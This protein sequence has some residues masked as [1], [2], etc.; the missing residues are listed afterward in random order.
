[1]KLFSG[2]AGV[3]LAIAAIFFL[4]YSIEHGWLEPPVRV[5]IGI[6]VSIGLLV[7]CELK[8]ARQY[9]VTANALD[10]AA[11]AILFA[12]FFAAH[13]LWNLI[14]GGVAFGLLALVTAVAVL[15]SIRRDS[16]F[17]A[18]LGLLGGFATPALL[19]TGENRPIPLFAYLLLL[20]LGLAWVAYR[21]RWPLLS[22]LTVALTAVYQWGWVFKFL[23][24]SQLSLATGIFLLF[25][26]VTVVALILARR[27][28]SGACKQ[29]RVD[30]RA[31]GA[32]RGRIAVALRRL[33]CCG[34]GLRTAHRH[35]VRLLLLVDAGLLAIALARKEEL[36][37]AV[38]AAGTVAVLSLWLS[39]SY[40]AGRYTTPLFMLP[41]F[42]TL[43]LF[44]P[45]LARRLARPFRREARHAVYVAPLLL[46]AF[47]VFAG[48]P[49][50][51]ASPM[52]LFAVLLGLVALLAWRALALS[53]GALYFPALFFSI[54][55]QAVWTSRN[56]SPERFGDAM[57]IYAALGALSLGVPLAARR[58]KRSLLPSWGSG[59]VLLASLGF[60]MFLATGP[61]FPPA[62]WGFALLTL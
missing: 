2:I 47:A 31:D 12:T 3:A 44:A 38:G 21:K 55:A 16:M 54:A 46:V 33:S 6:L 51:M 8:V 48:T 36:L 45:Q 41:L 13:S 14:P 5:I 23:T 34:A 58:L 42:V 37:H 40:D 4:S 30:V 19:S 50:A 17:I 28:P 49:Q 20:N 25:P 10:A 43:F 1:M 18:V 35:P 61:V 52:P 60:M 53:D 7:V 56:L 26:L 32:G 62:L 39:K 29:R 11:I 59:A 57:A 24:A 27:P 15:L 22:T 9:R